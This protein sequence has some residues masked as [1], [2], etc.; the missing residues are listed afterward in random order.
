MSLASAFPSCSKSKKQKNPTK[1]KTKQKTHK[2][3]IF[4]LVWNPF[5]Q[6]DMSHMTGKIQL[7]SQPKHLAV[8]STQFLPQTQM[9]KSY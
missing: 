1:P 4:R 6:L 2:T 9:I 8:H 5:Y 3:I 7:W